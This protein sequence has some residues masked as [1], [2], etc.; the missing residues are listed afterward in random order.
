M[1]VRRGLR[2]QNSRSLIRK[3]AP[4]DCGSLG[5]TR[6]HQA[7]EHSGGCQVRPRAVRP[8]TRD[9]VVSSRR[10]ALARL[11]DPPGTSLGGPA[12][13]AHGTR[14]GRR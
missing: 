1:G 7:L 14:S 5:H 8:R 3:E 13:T 12:A 2:V 4:S 11:G 9:A 10:G 6:G